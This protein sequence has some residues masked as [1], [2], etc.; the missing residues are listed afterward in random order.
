MSNLNVSGT[1]YLDDDRADAVRGRI[2]ILEVTEDRQ[3]KVVTEH[4][5]KGACRCLAM[6]GDKI[7]AALIKTVR[8]VPR[9]RSAP[10]TDLILDRRLLTHLG[11]PVN[12]LPHE[13]S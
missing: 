13:T 4:D 12:T 5:V 7:V 9:K 6:M 11:N 8:F 3:L 10:C 1:A 2:I